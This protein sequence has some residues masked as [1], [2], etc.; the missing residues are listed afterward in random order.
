M[1]KSGSVMY[2]QSSAGTPVPAK[3]LAVGFR[4]GTPPAG[5][6]ELT[7]TGGTLTIGDGLYLGVNENTQG[8][9]TIS[10]G[11]LAAKTLE[12]GIHG[13][14]VLDIADSAA[15]ITLTNLRFGAAGQLDAAAGSAV[16]AD[17]ILV[18]VRPGDERRRS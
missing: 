14:G 12:V 16:A 15:Q 9:Y 1:M 10:G 11:S 5:T 17:H 13:V 18:R 3:E 8:T 4:E 7:Q 6:G 2:Q